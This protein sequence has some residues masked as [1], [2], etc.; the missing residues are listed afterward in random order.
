MKCSQEGPLF[1]TP[2]SKYYILSLIVLTD[3]VSN[4]CWGGSWL[5]EAPCPKI[6]VPLYGLQKLWQ[7]PTHRVQS[8]FV[9]R[10]KLHGASGKSK[11][12]KP[13][14]CHINTISRK[15]WEATLPLG[16]GRGKSVLVQRLLNFLI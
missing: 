9:P 12:L 2:F 16:Q 3:L 4:N 10:K 7:M 11:L 5:P 14:R 8:C 1:L 13:A 6:S 15:G